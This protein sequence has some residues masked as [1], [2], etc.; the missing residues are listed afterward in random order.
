MIRN[1]GRVRGRG[2]FM[3]DEKDSS[4]VRCD[5]RLI[6][7]PQARRKKLSQSLHCGVWRADAKTADQIRIRITADWDN[8]KKI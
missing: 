3:D 7:G 4:C 1:T 2:F 6:V 8:F 5:A